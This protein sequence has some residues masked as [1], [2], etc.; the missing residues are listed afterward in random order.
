[1][2]MLI[3]LFILL[4]SLGVLIWS[5]D[6]FVDGASGTSRHLGISPLIVG[7]IVVGF[8]TSAPEMLVSVLSAFQGS[9][10]LAI[11]NALGSNISN[12][13]LILGVT[14]LISPIAVQSG[15]L[16]KEMPILLL[17]SI[18]IAALAADLNISRVDGLLMLFSF[19]LI[20]VWLVKQS[21]G[22]REDVLSMEAEQLA[23]LGDLPPLKSSVI[24]LLAGLVLLILSSKFLVDSA[25]FL[26]QSL[27][28]S[29]LVI[30]LTVVAVG[31]SLPEL[32][33]SL[34]A[35]RRNEHDMALG[36]VIGSNLFNSLVAIGAAGSIAPFVV[37]AGEALRDF[38]VVLALTVLLY[39]FCVGI[40]GRQGRINRLEGG[41]LL[42]AYVG[43]MA[44]LLIT[45][46]SQIQ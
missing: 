17:I 15:L 45:T 13:G 20:T 29:D 46:T 1:S 6:L 33:S 5:S 28:I 39:V 30:G 16:R 36:N 37:N 18:M 44:Y 25:V 9:P 12:I 8:G 3:S 21:M 23:Q 4:A 41:V 2:K 22:S 42:T 19:L 27:G 38:G 10:G 31:T 34:A 40:K 11:G 43:Y 26:A 7:M 35:V 32:A 24:R 14:A